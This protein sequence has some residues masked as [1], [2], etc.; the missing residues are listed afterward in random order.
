M[1]DMDALKRMMAAA[2]HVY[3]AKSECGCYTAV[4]TDVPAIK[5][6]TARDI[7]SFI[8]DGRMVERMTF[9]EW[10]EVLKSGRFG[11]TCERRSKPREAQGD[12]LD[13]PGVHDE[14]K[15]SGRDVL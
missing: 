12:M 6:E 4:V 1:S 11:H 7:A 15:P 3:A 10:R 5:R 8:R 13:G 14:P 2:T 9:A